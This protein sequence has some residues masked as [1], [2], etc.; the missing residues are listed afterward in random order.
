MFTHLYVHIPFCRRKCPYCS[1]FSQVPAE[2]DL[3]RYVTLL[4]D[5]MQLRS[6]TAVSRTGLDSIYFG[7]GTPSLL[8]PRQAG[9][10]LDLAGSLFGVN[11]DAEITL[12]AN[13]GTIGLQELSGYRAT[14]INRLSLG[15]QSFDDQMLTALGRI[16]TSRQAKEAF[17]AARRA[18]F[19]TIG[20]DLIHSLPG[21]T[22]GMWLKELEQAIGLGPEHLSVYGL[23]IEEGTPFAARYPE[24]SSQ[25]PDQDSSAD[26]FEAA[27]DR[28][29]SCGYEHY[30]I[31][32]YALP[33]RRS[34]HNSGYWKRDGYLGLGAAA[35]S[36]L[37]D[38]GYGS[39]SCN[40]SSLEA[41]AAAL[42]SG[43]LAY[44][45]IVPLDYEDAVA[46]WFF[47]GLRMADGVTYSAFREEFGGEMKDL[48]ART[49][50]GLIAQGLLI[51]HAGGIRLTR[52]GMLL[53]NQ[54][55]QQFLP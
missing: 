22:S 24:Q 42:Q 10:L 16:H 38:A 48:F 7:G 35:H 18:G 51:E 1:F 54:V 41:Y 26:M 11:P 6:T 3:D 15:V 4:Q 43:R 45:D 29:T 23:T 55:F 32:N 28:L 44:Q 46:E 36:F 25:L 37:K 13:P 2:G 20:I 19:D 17:S 49:L 30:E 50:H 21:Q 12:E 31:A 14:G 9:K 53:S 52:R 40:A 27:D 33:G 47:L 34:L 8:T 5:E 39:R